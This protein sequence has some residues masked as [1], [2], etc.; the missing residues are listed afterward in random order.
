M[1]N[2]RHSGVLIL[3]TLITFL[4]CE[5]NITYSTQQDGKLVVLSEINQQDSLKVNLS[6]SN[7]GFSNV[8]NAL[9]KLTNL[10]TN[11]SEP[12]APQGHG[13]YTGDK[14]QSGVNYKLSV[15]YSDKTLESFQT[16]PPSFNLKANSVGKSVVSVLIE[17]DH[18]QQRFFTFELLAKYYQIRYFYLLN[19]QRFE[20]Q[21]DSLLIEME[22]KNPNLI[23]IRDTTFANQLI[24][25][26][27][28]TSDPKTENVKY[29]EL[30]G[31]VG[32]I[33]LIQ[34]E[35]Y[36]NLDLNFSRPANAMLILKAKSVTP[37]YFR[38]LYAMDLQVANV[39]IGYYNIPLT[40]NISN[41]LGIFG[42]AYVKQI[43]L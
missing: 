38:Y 18:S 25:L 23:T 30:K 7:T 26:K 16:I 11:V 22:G 19:N 3:F 36:V 2:K 40:G 28:L 5:K 9:V 29:N 8:D 10:E 14:T 20:V 39:A 42:A 27:F 15:Q 31:I 35:K 37:E 43:P 6:R 4:S 32:R 24:R 17:S 1:K 41:A 12:L 33:F 34:K 13:N 21:S